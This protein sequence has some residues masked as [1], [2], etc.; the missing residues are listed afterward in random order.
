MNGQR[1]EELVVSQ[2]MTAENDI[3]AHGESARDG[4]RNGGW[5]GL[6]VEQRRDPKCSVVGM[7]A[8]GGTVLDRTRK[9]RKVER[10]TTEEESDVLEGKGG[11]GRR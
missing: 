2:K 4:W 11:W 9:W 6:C 5:C 7:K 10:C 3:M 1:C 8:K